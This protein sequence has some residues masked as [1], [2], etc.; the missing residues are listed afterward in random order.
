MQLNTTWNGNQWVNSNK[1][2]YTYDSNILPSELI[3]PLDYSFTS[4][5]LSYVDST[6]SCDDFGLGNWVDN[7]SNNYYWSEIQLS[8]LEKIESLLDIY[9][10][11]NPA[12]DKINIFCQQKLNRIEI[13]D[14]LGKVIYQGNDRTIDISNYIRGTYFIKIQLDKGVITKKI[15]VN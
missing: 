13:I 14:L 5:L 9:I 6:W 11:P 15:I 7:N 3:F 10:Y 12:K 2:E 8:N 1:M 4:Q